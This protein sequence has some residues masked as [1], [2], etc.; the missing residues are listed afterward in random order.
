MNEDSVLFAGRLNRENSVSPLGSLSDRVTA[1]Q[2]SAYMRCSLFPPGTQT[3]FSS[4]EF[5]ISL[6]L[7]WHDLRDDL[8]IH[9]QKVTNLREV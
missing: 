9:C 7:K 8:D 1:L 6:G 5:S 3:L 4:V 2:K